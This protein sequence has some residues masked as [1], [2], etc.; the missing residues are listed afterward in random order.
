MYDDPLLSAQD[1]KY[2][3][4]KVRYFPMTRRRKIYAQEEA[5]KPKYVRAFLETRCGAGGWVP[6]ADLYAAYLQYHTEAAPDIRAPEGKIIFA[7]YVSSLGITK[8][9]GRMGEFRGVY[10]SGISL[11]PQ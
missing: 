3:E 5:N 10:F 8:K 11:Q 2:L 9:S 4:E 7:R 6:L 1:K